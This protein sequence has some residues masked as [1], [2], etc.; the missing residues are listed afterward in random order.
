L[1]CLVIDPAPLVGP[2]WW[3]RR[4]QGQDTPRRMGVLESLG[5]VDDG[6]E[7]RGDHQSDAGHRR[8]QLKDWLLLGKLG[9]RVLGELQLVSSVR[10]M[11]TSGAMRA[12]V[13]SSIDSPSSLRTKFSVSHVGNSTPA[14]RARPRMVVTYCARVSTRA[15]RTL[16]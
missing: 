13:S 7:S 9:E 1:P 11:A 10:S 15:P 2:P 5:L 12:R 8:Q 6:N 4:G 14:A 3:T 16:S